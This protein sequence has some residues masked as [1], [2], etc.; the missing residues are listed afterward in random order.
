MVRKMN[1]KRTAD[2]IQMKYLSRDISIF[3]NKI[4]YFNSLKAKSF[5]NFQNN[6]LYILTIYYLY[7]IGL[8]R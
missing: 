2:Q 6:M 7:Y 8:L 3:V 5:V 4:Y 1:K